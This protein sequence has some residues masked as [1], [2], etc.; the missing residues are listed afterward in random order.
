M[1]HIFHAGDVGSDQVILMLETIAPV[2]AVRGNMDHGGLAATLP[3][4]AVVTVSGAVFVVQHRPFRIVDDSLDQSSGVF[5]SGHTHRPEILRDGGRLF[6]NPGSAGRG[7]T[8][9]LP[10]VGLVSVGEGPPTAEIVEL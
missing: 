1:S 7:L 2:T 5:V 4:R 8:D 10:T 3:D 9:S 6:V